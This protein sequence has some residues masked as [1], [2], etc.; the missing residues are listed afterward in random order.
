MPLTAAPADVAM[1]GQ[2][3]IA[4]R[5]NWQ[6]GSG[7]GARHELELIR[8]ALRRLRERRFELL[9]TL[10]ATLLDRSPAVICDTIGA[11]KGFLE[12]VYARFEGNVIAH[13]A[14]TGSRGLCARVRR[15]ALRA[16]MARRRPVSTT[17]R[18][19]A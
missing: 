13:V 6:S 16:P 11:L 4:H 5:P 17:E 15:I 10:F 14:E 18:M 8:D 3:R 7:G 19:S 2:A 1:S 9:R 12:L